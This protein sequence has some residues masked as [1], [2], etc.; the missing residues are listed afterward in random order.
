ME[1]RP[2]NDHS[3]ARFLNEQK[4]MGSR[5]SSC[6]GLFVPPRALCPDCH[7]ITLSWEQVRVTGRLVS[8]THISVVPPA[9]AEEGFDRD[10]PYCTGVVE[11]QESVRVVARI[12]GT[13][14]HNTPAIRIG[15]PVRVVFPAQRTAGDE[16][17]GLVCT[18]EKR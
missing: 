3:F 4:L 5:C 15:M 18:P 6:Q 17:I 16:P 10:N 11:L 1:T 8:F 14:T 13:D 12:E 2:F 7:G 9:I